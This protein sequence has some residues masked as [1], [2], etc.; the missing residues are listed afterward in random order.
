MITH[1]GWSVQLYLHNTKL[2]PFDVQTDSFSPSSLFA[3]YAVPSLSLSLGTEWY[4]IWRDD[5]PL[6]T[7]QASVVGLV[8][9][10]EGQTCSNENSLVGSSISPQSTLGVYPSVKGI[11]RM[12]IAPLKLR[13]VLREGQASP[14]LLKDSKLPL[15]TFE[16]VIFPESGTKE[17]INGPVN[18]HGQRSL[19]RFIVP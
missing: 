12:G 14:V 17:D 7:Q 15:A 6:T 13:L 4:L 8:H 9:Q 5:R 2:T 18:P 11:V 3:S 10:I 1:C 19:L 16:L